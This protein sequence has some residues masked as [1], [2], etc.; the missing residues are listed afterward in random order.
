LSTCTYEPVRCFGNPSFS[1]NT[2]NAFTSLM[3]RKVILFFDR[4][5]QP[6]GTFVEKPS[7]YI[8][9]SFNCTDQAPNNMETATLIVSD[10]G[11]ER[12]FREFSIIYVYSRPLRRP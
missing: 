12:H 1:T 7:S 3:H 11:A 8:S 5:R 6:G 4:V 10:K 9:G 2:A